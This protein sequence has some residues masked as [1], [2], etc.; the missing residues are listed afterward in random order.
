MY[1]CLVISFWVYQ[2]S[3]FPSSPSFL[4]LPFSSQ[5]FSW[6]LLNPVMKNVSL[7]HR[8]S[9]AHPCRA[10]GAS[11]FRSLSLLVACPVHYRHFC[12]LEFNPGH[13]SSTR[14]VFHLDATSY[15]GKERLIHLAVRSSLFPSSLGASHCLMTQAFCDFLPVT[16]EC[17]YE[18]V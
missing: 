13:F 15:T 14:L 8:G 11:P 5:T 10:L 7:I 18:R 9:T 16:L 1:K 2:S 17:G 6:S 12:N 4:F 3:T